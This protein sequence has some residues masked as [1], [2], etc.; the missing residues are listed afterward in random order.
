MMKRAFVPAL[1]LLLPSLAASQALAPA[2]VADSLLA[3]DRQFSEVSAKSDLLSA[4]SQMFSDEVAVLIG[5]RLHQGKAAALEALRA[6]PLVTKAV[7]WVPAHVGVSADGRHGFTAG[8]VSAERDGTPEPAKYLAYW[9]KQGDAWRVAVFKRVRA[10]E[11][12]PAA[13][14]AIR[15]LPERMLLANADSEMTRHRDSLAA[16]E[17]A[18]SREAQSIGLGPAFTKYGSIEAINL[19]GADKSTFVSGN[20]A[21]G[22][23]VGR[24]SPEGGSPLSWGPERVIVASSGDFGVTIGTITANSRQPGESQPRT[25]GFFTIWRRASPTE[26]WRYIAE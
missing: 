14:P 10:R 19:G 2:A 6:A 1:L 22:E 23:Y 3:A 5:G 16:A 4:F 15:V 26:P 17:R 12:P 24:G 7:R 21:I 25:V 18:F 9:V 13:P 11:A 20:R 8:Y